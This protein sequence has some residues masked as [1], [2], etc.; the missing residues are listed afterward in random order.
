MMLKYTICFLKRGD[1]ILLLNRERAPW[2]GRWNGVG[3]KLERG[4]SPKECA[5]REIEEETGIVLT[6]IT[7]KGDIMWDIDDS[8]S[9]G[10]YAF[11]AE[12][13]VTLDFPTPRKTT[14]GILD[15]KKIKWVLDPKNDG[16]ANL[17]YFLQKMLYEDER[18]IHHFTY[19]S[20]DVLNFSSVRV[21][22]EWSGASK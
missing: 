20:D 10:M 18:Y 8:Y 3:G 13:P 12:L 17:K 19:E 1:E 5:L 15:W 14:E 4:E 9:G 7:Y 2:M 11:V 6:D 21:E 16:L 22:P